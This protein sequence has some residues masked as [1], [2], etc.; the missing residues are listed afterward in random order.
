LFCTAA[1]GAGN[2]VL[3]QTG[4]GALNHSCAPNLGWADERTLV[5]LRDIAT[6][7]ELTI[8][9]ATVIADPQF[10]MTCHCETYRC[11]QVVEGRDWQIP[12]LQERYAG[13]WAPS[14]QRL[15]DGA[16]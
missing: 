6:G 1:I 5:A 10:V 8:D 14:V 4:V 15:I 16:G 9:Y 12:Q 7:D 2:V 13:H 3:E 11:R